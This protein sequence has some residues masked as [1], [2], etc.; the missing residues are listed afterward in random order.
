M[1]PPVD[2]ELVD[3]AVAWARE[4]GD[5]TLDWFRRTDLTVD[6]K[7]DGSP[8]TA[9]DRSAERLLRSRIAG[10]WPDDTIAGEEESDKVGT[11]TRTWIIDPVDGTKAFTHGV[12][13]YSTL[14]AVLDE[15]GPAVGVIHLPALG[16]TVWAGRGLGCFADGVPCTVSSHGSIDGAYLMTS[17]LDDYW[18]PEMLERVIESP[19]IVRTWGDGYGYALV[20]TGRAEAMIDPL[21]NPWDVAPMAVILPEAGG[22]FSDLSGEDRH[23][24]GNGLGSNGALHAELLELLRP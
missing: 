7:D 17:G 21:A 9:A 6:L 2:A 18:P 12:P 10:R 8:V 4:A 20:A 24:G 16:E 3:L 14:L 22:R 1:T 23:D 11:S 15:H 19:A 5:H 13:L